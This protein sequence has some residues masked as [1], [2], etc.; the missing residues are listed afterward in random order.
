[1][2]GSECG[3]Y[4]ALLNALKQTQQVVKSLLSKTTVIFTLTVT[5]HFQLQTTKGN[6]KHLLFVFTQIFL[7]NKKSNERK[8]SKN[9][10][11]KFCC[12]SYFDQ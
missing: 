2:K 6:V 12:V 11:A 1:V 9:S 5:R 7:A 10:S 3:V 4:W 8:T